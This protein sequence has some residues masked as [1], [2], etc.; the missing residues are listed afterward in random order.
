MTY[1]QRLFV[2]PAI[3]ENQ[4]SDDDEVIT[5]PGGPDDEVNIDSLLKDVGWIHFHYHRHLPRKYRLQLKCLN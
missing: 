4:L 2:D 3:L 5:L 1:L